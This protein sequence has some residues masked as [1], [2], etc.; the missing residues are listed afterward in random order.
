MNKRTA[1]LQINMR[2]RATIM[3]LSWV[4]LVGRYLATCTKR[5]NY[6]LNFLFGRARTSER[7]V[8]RAVSTTVADAVL[9]CLSF[10]MMLYQ[11][12]EEQAQGM[13]ACLLDQPS[14]RGSSSRAGRA[15]A[16][17][18]RR[19]VYIFNK[20]GREKCGTTR[21]TAACRVPCV[22]LVNNSGHD[23]NLGALCAQ[24]K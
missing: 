3:C 21:T 4:R 7:G 14:S 24:G 19:L 6:L 5:N 8:E 16:V 12:E 2:Q 17:P 22:D 11:D 18:P 10:L 1:N 13:Q 15:T 9:V 23:A 20:S